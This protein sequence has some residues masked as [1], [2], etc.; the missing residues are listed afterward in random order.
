MN[1]PANYHQSVPPPRRVLVWALV[2]SV[3]T[4]LVYAQTWKFQMLY[5]DD[6]VNV[7]EN[8]L[9][10]QPNLTGLKHIFTKPFSTDYYPLTYISLATDHFLWGGRFVGYH[11]TQTLLHSL[12]V[13]LVVLLGYR[14]TQSAP[15]ALIAGAWFAWHPVQVETVAWIA[16]RKNEL[17]MCLFLLA[18]LAYLKAGAP[19]EVTRPTTNRWWRLAS[20]GLFTLAVLSHALVIVMPA[21][22][23]AYELC[24]RRARLTEAFRHTWLFFVPAGLGALMRVFGHSESGQL[25]APFHGFAQGVLTMTKV[26][27]EHLTSL[28]WPLNLS[29][30]YT[31]RGVQTVADAGFLIGLTWIVAWIIVARRSRWALFAGLWFLIA[32]APVLQL[33]PHPTLRADRYL[34]VASLGI[35]WT[36]ALAVQRWKWWPQLTAIALL[37]VTF[38]RIPAWRDAKSLWSDCVAKQPSSIVG[39]FSM[40][41]CY[42]REQ[43]WPAAEKELRTTLALQENFAEGQARLGGV[44]LMQGKRD[45][46]RQ[47][48]QRALELDPGL[49]EARQNLEIAGGY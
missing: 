12:N 11:V 48:L 16:E 22:L 31:E 45:E 43:N 20:V 3:V 49:V 37:G 17:G 18:W 2:L 47:H 41:G 27:G 23:I 40:S 35:F 38:V 39:H 32:L 34:Y 15:A 28:V 42:V 5:W 44:L 14:F 24:L 19:R 10:Q 13:L 21:L 6:D 25:V 4:L 33:V 29:N 30:H 7:L 8:P 36:A 26:L 9:V 46:A 1:A